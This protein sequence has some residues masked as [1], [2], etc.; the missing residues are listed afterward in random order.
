MLAVFTEAE[1]DLGDPVDRDMKTSSC[2][3]CSMV[4]PNRI[5]KT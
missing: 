5:G 2:S 4:F 1:E 3:Y